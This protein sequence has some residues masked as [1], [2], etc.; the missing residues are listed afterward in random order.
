MATV[1]GLKSFTISN[2][3]IAQL[4]SDLANPTPRNVF[5]M[6][7]PNPEAQPIA[8]CRVF[9]R[10][11]WHGGNARDIDAEIVFGIA[12]ASDQEF[13]GGV[14]MDIL[15]T[16]PPPAEKENERVYAPRYFRLERNDA[17]IVQSFA[18][19]PL[20]ER[21]LRWGIFGAVTYELLKEP[22]FIET[23][24][25]PT[26]NGPWLIGLKEDGTYWRTPAAVSPLRWER[27]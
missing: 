2:N 18:F 27:I 8:I 4:Y 3:V 23:T 13:I 5:T 14:A 15:P 12:R 10:I 16:V 22:D 6:T 11:H 25:V 7:I 17:V 24:T 19:G 20:P 9:A 21:E 1:P 26:A